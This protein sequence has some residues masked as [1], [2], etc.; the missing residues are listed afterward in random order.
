MSTR[1]YYLCDETAY[2]ELN[3]ACA[4][5]SID[6]AVK[7]KVLESCTDPTELAFHRQELLNLQAKELNFHAKQLVLL[8]YV[9]LLLPKYFAHQIHPCSFFPPI[10]ASTTRIRAPAWRAVRS[11]LKLDLPFYGSV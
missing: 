6:V 7:Q 5:I 11:R 2:N 9:N 4:K 10:G 3:D 8:K 1:K